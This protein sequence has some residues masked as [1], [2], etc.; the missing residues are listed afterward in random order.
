MS[1][2]SDVQ[3]RNGLEAGFLGWGPSAKLRDDKWLIENQPYLYRRRTYVM[4]SH[5][6]NLTEGSKSSDSNRLKRRTLEFEWREA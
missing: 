5:R 2:G 6:V 3:P 1:A 4:L